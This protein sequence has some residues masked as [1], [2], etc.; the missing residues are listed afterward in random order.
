MRACAHVSSCLI[1]LQAEALLGAVGGGIGALVT[2][3]FD[4]FTIRIIAAS[5]AEPPALETGTEGI[6]GDGEVHQGESVSAGTIYNEIMATTGP[7]GLMQ[8]SVSRVLYWAPAIGI[9]LSTY[10]FLRQQ[11]LHFL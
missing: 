1:S 3:P 4:I 7:L 8:G 2:T 9:F 10:C 11:A 5:E 6:D